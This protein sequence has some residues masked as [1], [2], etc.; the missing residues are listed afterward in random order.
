[1]RGQ[2]VCSLETSS[3]AQIHIWPAALSY[4]YFLLDWCIFLTL[5]AAHPYKKVLLITTSQLVLNLFD[6][7]TIQFAHLLVT[8][9]VNGT[10]MLL[11]AERCAFFMAYTGL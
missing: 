10:G 8:S 11:L 2:V 4:Y 1:M 7:F 9:T 3:R 6:L 5:P